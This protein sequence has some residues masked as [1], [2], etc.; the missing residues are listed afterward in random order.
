MK[1]NGE[2]AAVGLDLH[3][4]VAYVVKRHN[5]ICFMYSIKYSLSGPA[6]NTYTTCI[7][8][9]IYMYFN[10]SETLYKKGQRNTNLEWQKETSN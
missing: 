5:Y 4:N 8:N 2:R 9:L 6:Y 3:L 7:L 10:D 1:N